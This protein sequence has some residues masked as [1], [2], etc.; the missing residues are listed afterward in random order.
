M[1]GLISWR[2]M[3]VA[4]STSITRS[5]GTRFQRETVDLLMLSD[6][7]RS[8]SFLP[9]SCRKIA[10]GFVAIMTP[11]SCATRHLSSGILVVQCDNDRRR[12]SVMT[13]AATLL[14][15]ASLAPPRALV[16]LPALRL[17]RFSSAIS[18]A[19]ALYPSSFY[20]GNPGQAGLPAYAE[21]GAS[22]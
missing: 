15:L 6:E 14:P 10:K 16:I 3:P 12:A 5:A 9:R 19:Q 17:A 8:L 20:V 22:A 13:L 11:Y 4:F 2:G 7:A 1:S 18:R 21:E